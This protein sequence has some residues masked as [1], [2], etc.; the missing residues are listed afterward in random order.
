MDSKQ[1]GLAV[2]LSML[3]LLGESKESKESTTS[4]PG[5]IN[6]NGKGRPRN[7]HKQSYLPIAKL[8]ALRKKERQA[9]RKGRK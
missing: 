5:I 9:K 4:I 3:S 2:A 8:R 6:H 7:T 1:Q